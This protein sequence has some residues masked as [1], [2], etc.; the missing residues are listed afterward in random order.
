[1]GQRIDIRSGFYFYLAALIF[2]LS[3]PW[4]CAA[5]TAA[6]LHEIG[7]I[8]A[9]HILCLQI[10][11]ICLDMGGAQIKT[12]PASDLQTLLTALAG[13]VIGI[14]LF[15]SFR[16]FPRLAFCGLIQS[17]FNL[18]PIMPF[19]GGRVLLSLCNLLFGASRGV[20]V[21]KYVSAILLMIIGL[22]LYSLLNSP[23][24]I[25]MLFALLSL[26]IRHEKKI[27]LAN[28]L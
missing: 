14:L 3:L 2:L 4:L 15:F 13:P 18:I 19:D 26:G 12:S 6:I 23:W 28:R 16:A 22:L 1:M 8:L 21:Y 9:A 27:L 17:A 11:S 25:I 10:H 24:V 20:K 7:H 5:L